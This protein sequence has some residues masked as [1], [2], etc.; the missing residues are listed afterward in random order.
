MPYPVE[1]IEDAIVGALAPLKASL[2]V[3]EIKSYQGEL[4]EAD[5]KKM[6]ARFPA[7][8]VVYG[9]SVYGSHGARKPETM[10]FSLFVCDRSLRSEEES[11]R[12]GA[13]NPGTYRMLRECR[14]LITGK[15]L[16][17]AELKP[18]E[19]LRDLSIWSGDGISIYAQDY[20]TAQAHLYPTP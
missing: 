19:I 6:M 20:E 5:I 3:R 14:N 1:Q 4:E 8:Y 7:I 2:G 11:R 10:T 9:D 16:G 15:N 18:F 17:L 12:G 13:Q